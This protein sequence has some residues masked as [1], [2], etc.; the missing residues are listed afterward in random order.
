MR[1]EKVAVKI[2]KETRDL[3]NEL[4]SRTFIPAVNLM[5][6]LVKR[7]YE[8]FMESPVQF[9]RMILKEDEGTERDVIAVKEEEKGEK[10]EEKTADEIYSFFMNR[11]KGVDEGK[12]K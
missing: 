1:K 11:L 3:L 4:S 5:D 10:K 6:L 12:D 7:A 9:Y 2:F 8:M